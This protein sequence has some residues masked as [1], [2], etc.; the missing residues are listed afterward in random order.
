MTVRRTSWAVVAAACLYAGVAGAAPLDANTEKM[1]GFAA[2][3]TAMAQA[4]KHMSASEIDTAKAKQRQAM[5]GQ[6]IDAKAYDAAYD[7]AQTQFTQRWSAMPAAKQ[8]ST[9]AEVK[10]QSEM[11]AAQA[12]KMAK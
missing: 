1:V 10:K 9:C 8:Q 7:A 12:N 5:L 6:G 11:A 4:C 3:M 2:S